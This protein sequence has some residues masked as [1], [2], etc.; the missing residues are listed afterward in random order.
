[1]PPH[2]PYLAIDAM[3]K[4]YQYRAMPFGARHSPIFFAQTLAIVLSKIRRESDI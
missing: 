3:G 4:V 2:R 1:Y